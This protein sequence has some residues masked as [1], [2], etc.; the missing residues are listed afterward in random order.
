MDGSAI[1][2]L[3]FRFG[4]AKMLKT[5]KYLPCLSSMHPFLMFGCIWVLFAKRALSFTDPPAIT[6]P[7]PVKQIK[8]E[9]LFMQRHS[10]LILCD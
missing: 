2:Y 3:S 7:H 4:Y 1:L 10:A 9:Y 6:E 8:A 5:G